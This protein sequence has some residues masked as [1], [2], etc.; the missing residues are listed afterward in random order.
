MSAVKGRA[1]KSKGAKAMAKNRTAGR[2]LMR[3]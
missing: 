1:T 3:S 2:H